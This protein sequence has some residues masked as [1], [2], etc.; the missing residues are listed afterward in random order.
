MIANRVGVSA[1]E[2]LY[3]S[4]TD[5][6]D[7][8]HDLDF[9]AIERVLNGEPAT[10][11]TAEKIYAAQALDSRGY[12][13]TDIGKRIG[14]DPSTIRGWQANGWQA[15]TGRPVA[16]KPRQ[17]PPKCG[18]PRMYRRHLA[19]GKVPC[20]ACRAANAAADRRYRLT[21]SRTAPA[22]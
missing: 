4:T 20:T 10:L 17:D 16:P 1:R 22:A 3:L 5:T 9:I 8:D 18:E 15:G 19:L 12:T 14:S 2:R 7:S 13:A 21:G 11:T 6:Y